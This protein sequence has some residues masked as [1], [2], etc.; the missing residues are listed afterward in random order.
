MSK[1]KL[2]IILTIPTF[3]ILGWVYLLFSPLRET[4]ISSEKLAESKGHAVQYVE[5]KKGVRRWEFSN[6]KDISQTTSGFI[7][8]DSTDKIVS[9]L[10]SKRY[11]NYIYFRQGLS[12]SIFFPGTGY[13]LEGNG[14]LFNFQ[15]NNL[16]TV[17]N[18]Q[19]RGGNIIAYE[20]NEI[21][22]F[23]NSKMNEIKKDNLLTG[24]SSVVVLLNLQRDSLYSN[25]YRIKVTKHA[26][27][28]DMNF[29]IQTPS[30]TTE[31]Y[32]VNLY[33]GELKM[34]KSGPTEWGN[35][36]TIGYQSPSEVKYSVTAEKASQYGLS[37][38][39]DPK[40]FWLQSLLSFKNK[41]SAGNIRDGY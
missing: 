21:Y 33:N 13:F 27:S 20:N 31:Y 36:N 37:Y 1:K 26:N 35:N 24:T 8:I 12:P 6:H 25:L 7:I 22:Y 34:I 19:Y 32:S 14:D 30:S 15:D 11:K 16:Q 41:I 40:I 2:I 28:L 5:C 4:C 39:S 3:L 38:D 17:R 10:P 18:V 9:T 23:S 29:D